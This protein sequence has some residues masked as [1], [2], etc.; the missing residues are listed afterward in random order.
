M[1]MLV[2][3][4][5]TEDMLDGK[6]GGR[7]EF[8]RAESVFRNW[9]TPDGSAGP[10]G[11]SG[12][13]AE[14]DRYHL[15]VGHACPWAHRTHIFL[16][17]KG[18]EQIVS[19]SVVH[20]FMGPDG[21]SFEPDDGVIPDP[22]NGAKFI[23]DVYVASEPLAT[24]RC[25]IPVLFD[26]KS[27]VIVS[28]ESSEIIRMFNDAFDGAGATEGDY[29]PEPLRDEIDAVNERVYHTLNNGVYKCGFAFSQDAYEENVTALFDTLD[30]LEERLEGREYLVG[31]RPTEADWRLFPTLVRFDA[32]YHGHFKCN[33]RRIQD[34]PNMWAY[35]RRLYAMP[36]VA[37][38][39]R[40]DHIQGHYY[41]SHAVINPTRVV[42]IGPE[43]AFD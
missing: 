34:Y 22:I 15:Y 32:V 28:N 8:K 16:K 37:E 5:W 11:E 14:P 2:D 3:G 6:R 13:E 21:W 36:G 43:I 31:D 10:S 39:V 38:T 35:T 41:K 1:A 19:K 33:L 7:A 23:R 9:V 26:K 24:T 17:L 30:W 27:G 42:P 25:T 20:W 4:V 12:F 18:L 29:Y 40:L